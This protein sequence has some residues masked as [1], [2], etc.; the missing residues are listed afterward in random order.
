MHLHW[1]TLLYVCTTVVAASAV[2]MSVFGRTQRV[3]KGFGWWAL[4]Q[5]L[6]AAGLF[7]HVFTDEWSGFIP[8][9]H[10]LLL[11][12]P[13]VILGGMRRFHARHPLKV[14]SSVDAIV[15][16][17]SFWG[18]FLTWWAGG[19]LLVQIVAFCLSTMAVHFYNAVCLARLSDFRSSSAQQALVGAELIV[20]AIQGLQAVFFML[21]PPQNEIC[22]PAVG[23]PVVISALGMAFLSLLFTYE[24]TEGNL[25]TVHRKLRFLA[26]IDVVTL[27]PNRRHFYEQATRSLRHSQTGISALLMFDIDHF[28][29]INDLLG[30]AAGDEALRQVARC[31]RDTLRERD[32]AG[33]LGGDEFAVLLPETLTKDALT[34]AERITVGLQERQVVPRMAPISLSFGVVQIQMNENIEE[35]IRRADQALYEAKRQGRGCAVTAHGDEAQPVFSESCR[36]GLT[37]S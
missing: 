9:A 36:L 22:L 3:Y 10:G 30:H 23:I 14:P 17:L 15:W 6:L 20:V 26:D 37:A 32:V 21:S 24:R 34:V 28:K 29:Q 7:V 27:V 1:P 5:W 12:W 13:I 19:S 8:I 25:R 16:G 18:C 11:Q 35:A 2:A 31:V 33:R 4:A